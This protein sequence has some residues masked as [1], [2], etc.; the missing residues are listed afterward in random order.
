MN[1]TEKGIL[2]N[3]EQSIRDIWNIVIYGQKEKINKAEAISE[4]IMSS[5]FPKLMKGINSQFKKAQ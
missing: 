2:R 3:P 4:E 5:S 1:Y